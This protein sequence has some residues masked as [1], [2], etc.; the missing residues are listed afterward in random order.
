MYQKFNRLKVRFN[1]LFMITENTK[2]LMRDEIERITQ[3][4][5]WFTQSQNYILSSVKPLGFHYAINHRLHKHHTQESDFESHKAYS[6]FLHTTTTS[7]LNPT[8]F[9]GFYTIIQKCYM[10]NYKNLNRIRKHL[11]RHNAPTPY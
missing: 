3:R 8:D 2:S 1:R 7:S 6:L 5:S 10:N 4:L 11:V 9:T